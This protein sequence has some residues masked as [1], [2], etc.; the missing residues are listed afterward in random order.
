M[1]VRHKEHEG[2]IKTYNPVSAYALHILNNRH[3]YGNA[4]ETTE[5]LKSWNTRIKIN[6]WELFFILVLQQQN[7]LIKTQ[8]TIRK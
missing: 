4:E 3:E 6:F 2:Y 1:E 7:V 8:R 5:L